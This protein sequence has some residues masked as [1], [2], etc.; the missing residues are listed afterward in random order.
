ME[1]R[2]ATREADEDGETGVQ[3]KET[4]PNVVVLYEWASSIR[5]HVEELLFTL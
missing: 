1:M 5:Q 3:T 4:K 2:Q